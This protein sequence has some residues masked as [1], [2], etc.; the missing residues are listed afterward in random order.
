MMIRHIALAATSI[1]ITA[2]SAS[3]QWVTFSNQ[4]STRLVASPA[5]VVNDN[6]EKDFAWADFDK[7][8][9]TDLIVMRKFPGSIQ[10]GFRDLI[11]MNEGGVLTDR[12]TEYGTASDTA[13]YSAM[14]DPCNDRDVEAVDVD[15]DGWLDLVTATTMSD[16]VN[17]ILG[18]PRVYMNLRNNAGGQWQG[19]R[20]ED[21]RIPVLTA[22]SGS[23][24]NPR[25]CDLA[26]GDFTGDG[27]ADLYFVD[28]DTPETSGTICID[29]NSNGSTADTGECQQSPGESASLD[30]NNKLLINSGLANPGHFTDSGSTRM[31]TTQL[32]SAFGNMCMA[33][34]FNS[35]GLMDVIRVSTLTGGQDAAI[36]WNKTS[37]GG[38][39]AQWNGPD[40]IYPG[41]APYG[42]N[43]ADLTGDG[44]LDFV[45]ADDG[46]DR[47]CINTGN[48]T[49]GQAN[50]SISVI[51]DSVGEFGNTITIADFD[52][53]G[54]KDVIICDVDSDLGPFC[55]SSGRRTKFYRNTGVTTTLLDEI[56]F[57]IPQ[58][59][60]NSLYD[61]AAFDINGDGWLDVVTGGCYGLKVFINTPPINLTWS[62]PNG[63]PAVLTPGQATPIAV[64]AA[65]IG[66][67][68]VVVG[69]AKIY[70]RV[71]GGAW[72]SGNMTQQSATAF[73]GTL[74]ACNCGQTL[75][76]YV[77]GQLTNGGATL[78]TLPSGPAPATYFSA[79]AVLGQVVAF[80]D[81]MEGATTAWTV[82]NDPSLT[83][84][85]WA[86]ADPTGTTNGTAEAEPANDNSV[87]GTKCWV[88]YPAP[89]GTSSS[90]SDLDFGPTTLTSA[91]VAINGLDATLEYARWFFCNDALIPAEADALIVQIQM[92][93]GPWNT[94]ETVSSNAGA[95]V[96][97]SV[98]VAAIAPPGQT[99]RVRFVVS[100]PSNNSVTEAA[101]DDVVV[102][103]ALCPA[104]CPADL[105]GDSVITGSDL[106]ALLGAWGAS[107]AADLDGSGVVDGSDLAA[108]LG[109]WGNCP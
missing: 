48:G 37:A 104:A 84:G 36:I 68:S 18:Q 51:A 55:P 23:T 22:A 82:T 31:T 76:W 44:K 12:T 67:G 105:D 97:R 46:Q 41:L 89:A 11:L 4:T 2:V 109:A 91:P 83:V 1:A 71:G 102:K 10:G 61:A 3:A 26:V 40:S 62:L 87:V 28:Y 88:T 13:G 70:S 32:A 80:S 106:G 86:V 99:M 16:Q 60:L 27:F 69:S 57:P 98:Q 72:S 7:D 54:K 34:D 100:D 59:D 73:T 25:F 35:D 74:P 101:I 56:G 24:A 81:D 43:V 66:G 20:L 90:S 93:S 63:A 92:D 75:D 8:G 45:I 78:Y 47:Y 79:V 95:W 103:R 33:G 50:F 65:L 21:A 52:N 39:G 85:A 15:N 64:N 108:L 94:V 49:D 58:A 77:S 14:M 53:D 96:S 9:D 42:M 30:Y 19:F 29:L 5:L 17:A 107:G 6:L 38:V